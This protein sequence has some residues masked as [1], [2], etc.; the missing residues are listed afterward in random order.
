MKKTFLVKRNAL[1]SSTGFSWGTVALTGAVLALFL[2]LVAPNFFWSILTPIFRVAD[3]LA[4]Q[5]H[6]VLSSL[7]DTAALALQNETLMHENAALLNENRTLLQKTTSIATLPAS[8]AKERNGAS[9]ILAGVVARPPESSYDTLMLAEG[10]NTGVTLGMEVFGPGG[11]PIGVVSSVFADFSQATLFSAP[12]MV[13]HGW[14]GSSNIPLTIEG[15]GGGVMR[16]SLARSAGIAVGDTV[17][18]PGPG[19]LAIGRVTRIDSDPLAPVVT[20]RIIP[21]IN[22]FSVTW[23]VLRDTGASLLNTLLQASPNAP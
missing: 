1:L 13:T 9:G 7:G 4:A 21:A 16:A 17:F 12:G 14:V 10:M 5:S 20:L 19:A 23:V 8:S 2:R 6:F 11:V 3:T 22:L 15:S 18:G